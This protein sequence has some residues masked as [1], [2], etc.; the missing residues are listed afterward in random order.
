VRLASWGRS[1]KGTPDLRPSDLLK[2]ASSALH[3]SPPM[4]APLDA[5]FQ[6][7]LTEVAP[8][9]GD[10]QEHRAG[11]ERDTGDECPDPLAERRG[12]A[13]REQ[14]AGDCTEQEANLGDPGPAV[15][16]DCKQV[17]AG[18]LALRRSHVYRDTPYR[19]L[20]S[21]MGSSDSPRRS[22]DETG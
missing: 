22:T 13:E 5:L 16:G 9:H 12:G 14:S 11:G 18:I 2:G 20:R 21:G 4:A 3:A 17:H 1:R 10:D 15:V 8:A 7:R 6:E 19:R